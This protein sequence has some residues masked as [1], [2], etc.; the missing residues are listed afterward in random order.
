MPRNLFSILNVTR[1][2]ISVGET[3]EYI[4]VINIYGIGTSGLASLG[5]LIY[6]D[7]PN[8][9]NT[10]IKRKT[11]CF[12]FIAAFVISMVYFIDKDGQKVVFIN[13]NGKAEEKKVVTGDMIGSKVIIIS[14]IE[15]G[16]E[17]IT[18]GQ[19]LFYTLYAA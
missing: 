4:V 10:I 6:A 13:N 14:G 16:W 9:I 5:R 2:S 12:H 18:S 17:L 15:P 1:D 11:A 19:Q 3:P 8:I 7:D